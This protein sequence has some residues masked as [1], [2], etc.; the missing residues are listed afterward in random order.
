MN[1]AE[2]I[3]HENYMLYIKCEDGKAGLFGVK[4]YLEAEVFS[5]LKNKVEF[6]RLYNGKYY[7]E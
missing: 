5:P 6:E 4:P 1:I 2:V 3:P 7:I